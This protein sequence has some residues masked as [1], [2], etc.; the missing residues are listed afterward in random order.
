MRFSKKESS[1]VKIDI[2]LGWRHLVLPLTSNMTLI[3]TY[4]KSLH[5]SCPCPNNKVIG[6]YIAI[7]ISLSISWTFCLLH[8]VV[9]LLWIELHVYMCVCICECV[10]V[11]KYMCKYIYS[12]I[13]LVQRMLSMYFCTLC[14]YICLQQDHNV[15]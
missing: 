5:W 13:K 9:L 8:V 6:G 4:R 10:Y 12:Y 11:C 1:E 14:L 7:L 2:N 3:L 15:N